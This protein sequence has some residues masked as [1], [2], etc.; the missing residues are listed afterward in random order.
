MG[1]EILSITDNR[2][3]S[4]IRATAVAFLSLGM[5]FVVLATWLSLRAESAALGAYHAGRWTD[6]EWLGNVAT[7]F[8]GNA[9]MMG[10]FA[11]A[12]FT[13]S[14]AL[15][16]LTPPILEKDEETDAEEQD[17]SESEENSKTGTLGPAS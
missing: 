15:L 5:L 13:F 4:I 16:G 1:L 6:G 9:S 10:T 14:T 7:R 8:Y 3:I 11:A 17:D 2:K 12:C